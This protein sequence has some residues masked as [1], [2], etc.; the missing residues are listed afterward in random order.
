[1]CVCVFS[2]S[3]VSMC[4]PMDCSP[5]A[6]SAH[7][8][9]QARILEWVAISSSGASSQPKD[10]TCSSCISRWILYQCTT[11]E[12]PCLYF[13]VNLTLLRR[14]GFFGLWNSEEDSSWS[15]VTWPSPHCMYTQNCS[16]SLPSLVELH[17]SSAQPSLCNHLDK[18]IKL[19]QTFG[20]LSLFSLFHKF[21]APQSLCN[22][23]SVSL[24]QCPTSCIMMLKIILEKNQGPVVKVTLLVSLFSDMT[25]LYCLLLTSVWKQCF[26]IF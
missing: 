10:Q 19:K 22:L 11:W 13:K 14:F 3:V 6:F 8:I 21:Y 2:H 23:T 20:V 26:D 9:L 25:V 1:M 24:T 5:P 7:G 4:D 12:A 17:S 15:S 16:C 18:N